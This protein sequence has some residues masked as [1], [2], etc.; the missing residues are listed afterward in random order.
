MTME[1][2]I[3]NGIMNAIEWLAAEEI[4]KDNKDKIA[5]LTGQI[6]KLKLEANKKKWMF[7]NQLYNM[8]YDLIDESSPA[9]GIRICLRVESLVRLA[10]KLKYIDWSEFSNLLHYIDVQTLDYRNHSER[11][12]NSNNS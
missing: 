12:S 5:E 6:I 8:I 4:D 9:N 2:N 1:E 11:D 10:Y 7:L 3:E